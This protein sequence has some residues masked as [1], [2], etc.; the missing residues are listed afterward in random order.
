MLD[1]KSRRKLERFQSLRL[2][3]FS[4]LTSTTYSHRPDTTLQSI[5][6]LRLSDYSIVILVRTPAIWARQWLCLIYG[7]TRWKDNWEAATSLLSTLITATAVWR[8][9]SDSS[10]K[11]LSSQ[12]RSLINGSAKSSLRLSRLGRLYIGAVGCFA[13]QKHPLL[14]LVCPRFHPLSSILSSIKNSNRGTNPCKKVPV[15]KSKKVIFKIF[16]KTVRS[17][18]LDLRLCGAW[19]EKNILD[20][21]TALYPNMGGDPNPRYGDAEKPIPDPGVNKS[22]NQDPQYRL[23]RINTDLDGPWRM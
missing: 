13:M 10:A 23:L 11:G 4:L 7:G 12:Y 5:S 6:W 3:R 14:D 15:L 1:L 21:N 20:S 9:W 17:R 16:Y 8:M 18:N 22:T 19:A 2:I